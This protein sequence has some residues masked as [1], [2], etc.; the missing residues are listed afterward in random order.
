LGRSGGAVP[1]AIVLAS[2]V[3]ATPAAAQGDRLRDQC[4]EQFPIAAQQARE[5]CERAAYAIGITQPRVG[6][7]LTGGNPVPGTASTLGTRLGAIPRLSV[8]ARVTGA[9]TELPDIR[10][11][12]ATGTI[13]FPA[14][15]LNVD[16]AMGVF[17]GM[18]LLPTV[19]GFG[20]VDVLGSFGI[21][22][23]PEGRGFGDRPTSWALGAR[24]GLLRESFTMPGVSVSGMYR[25]VSDIRYGDA[26]LQEYDVFFS[27]DDMTVTSVRAAI[28]K[29]LLVVGLAGGVGWDRHASDITLRVRDPF[30]GSIAPPELRQNGFSSTRTTAFFNGS[31]TMLLLNIVAEG[32]WQAG[33]TGNPTSAQVRDLVERSGYYGS[34]ALRLAL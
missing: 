6:M 19:G 16:A 28:S 4:A 10:T 34:L 27:M 14:P 1:F 5:Y 3:M 20:S 23:L 25:R 26:Q 2:L 21:I 12:A 18:A 31:F 33:G 15:A 29:R 30:T 17:G 9:W 32:G 13:R 7:A 8:S 22:P 11:G 24:L